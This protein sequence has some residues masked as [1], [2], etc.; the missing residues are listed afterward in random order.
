VIGLIEI[1]III[2][3]V[4]N[5]SDYRPTIGLFIVLVI[6]ELIN[7]ILNLTIYKNIVKKDEKN[8]II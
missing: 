7:E 1:S 4:K 5:K 3:I 6:F 8:E 2:I